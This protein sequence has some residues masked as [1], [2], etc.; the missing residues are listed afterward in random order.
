MASFLNFTL[1]AVIIRILVNPFSNVLQKQI[2]L[3]GQHPL[4]INLATYTVLAF[5]SVFFIYDISIQSLDIEFW[6]YSIAGGITGAL[7]NGFIVKALE[8]GDLSVLGPI[9]AY[10]SIVGML[11]AF[12]IIREVPNIWGLMGM[13]F[14]IVGSYF[15]LDTTEEKFS[16][17]LFK[18]PAIQYRLA[19]LVLTGIQAVLDKKVIEHSNL[20]IA[21]AGWSIFGAGFSFIFILFTKVS[22]Q[23]EFKNVDRAIL[24]KY[25]LLILT[26]GLML[27][28]TNYTLSHMPV[29]YALALFQLSILISVVLGHRFFN[30]LHLFKK[31]MGAT[32]MVIGSA[33]IILMK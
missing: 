26:V 15:V 7:G 30:E 28:S 14:I 16:W 32:I 10:K 17:Q 21:F 27:A 9:N 1:L 5:I 2:T 31:L 20:E 6:I 13:G 29:G 11:F 23:K 22:I 25:F 18:T 4:F 24:V 8:K 3:K 19:A 12:I 33:L